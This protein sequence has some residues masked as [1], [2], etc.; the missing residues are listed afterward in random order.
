MLSANLV[1][2]FFSGVLVFSATMVDE[3]LAILTLF[4][5][6]F[7]SSCLFL[8]LF[9]IL[10]P[11]SLAYVDKYNYFLLDLD[12]FLKVNSLGNS[13]FCLVEVTRTYE[14]LFWCFILLIHSF[15]KDHMICVM[16]HLVNYS[17]IALSLGVKV[18]R[19]IMKS[20][21]NEASSQFRFKPIN[22]VYNNVNVLQ[23]ACIIFSD[24]LMLDRDMLVGFKNPRV[25]ATFC[26]GVV[27]RVTKKEYMK[28]LQRFYICK[29]VK[30]NLTFLQEWKLL[31][32]NLIKDVKKKNGLQYQ[33]KLI[34]F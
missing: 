12:L 27:I 11:T 13:F 29:G 10:K 26:K 4:C 7:L 18:R 24:K 19:E 3:K 33:V 32:S 1:F 30:R 9:S 34:N 22:K 15:M 6:L 14:T 28:V 5:K 25:T 8:H 31:E 23:S 2:Y 20:A 17:Y 16:L 21:G